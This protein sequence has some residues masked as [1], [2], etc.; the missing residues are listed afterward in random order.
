MAEHDARM[1]HEA[2]ARAMEEV[3]KRVE[4]SARS[5]LV[6]PPAL[7]P[8][9]SN[10]KFEDT[11]ASTPHQIAQSSSSPS[12]QSVKRPGLY[13]DQSLASRFVGGPPLSHSNPHM[14]QAQGAPNH[15]SSRIKINSQSEFV[16]SLCRVN[17]L[18]SFQ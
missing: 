17:N 16:I 11:T 5:A 15:Q 13:D 3:A 10:L 8:A 4:E 18:I 2:A 1:M 7:T 6:Q 12:S 14:G 9:V